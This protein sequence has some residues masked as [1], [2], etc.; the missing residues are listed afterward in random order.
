MT[1]SYS[2]YDSLNVT[3][4]APAEVIRAA[5]RSLSQKHHPDKNVGDQAAAQVMMRLNAA[6]SVLS[7]E[8]Q[9]RRYDLQFQD[10]PDGNPGNRAHALLRQVRRLA[11][12]RNGRLAAVLLGATAMVS[13]PITW[14]IWKDHQT[15]LRIEQGLI[16]A[17]GHAPSPAAE[18]PGTADQQRAMPATGNARPTGPA[19]TAV[20]Q[21]TA[22][23]ALETSS[24]ARLS[25]APAAASKM[26]DYAR[27]SAMLKSMG[28][29]LY[30][31]DS[32]APAKPAQPAPPQAPEVAKAEPA[33]PASMP[34]PVAAPANSLVRDE[35]ARPA[36]PPAPVRGDVKSAT[37]ASPVIAASPAKA[38]AAAASQAA[39][40]AV[41]AD[42]HNCVAP[43][44]PLNAYRSGKTG[45]V[46]LA[47][48]IGN[49]GRVIESKVQ[50]SSGSSELDRA[51]RDALA[52]C[53]FKPADGQ[54]TPAW[55]NLTYV[56]SID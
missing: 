39:R 26:T 14:L 32:S 55:A 54:T 40:A 17:A 15:T 2:H 51:A 16:D 4:D 45:S 56:W 38:D 34:A 5:Y 19:R 35:T 29:G 9:R 42:A 24:A 49:D 47:M 27:L 11:R 20:I 30:K 22:P 41:V 36:A 10:A 7:D 44:Y 12:G 1:K 3:R 28:L 37:E 43:P 25:P 33:P 52:L 46:L 21:I 23:P 18:W 8:E 50:K 31:L 48:L 6:Y 53:K 13:A